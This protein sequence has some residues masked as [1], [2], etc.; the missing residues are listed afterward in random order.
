MSFRQQQV[1]VWC[2]TC[3]GSGSHEVS[4]EMASDAGEPGMEGMEIPCGD[5]GGDGWTVDVETVATH[6]TESVLPPTQGCSGKVDGWP[7][8]REPGHDAG[9]HEEKAAK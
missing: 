2:S 5:C 8:T 1:Q 7:C 6:T 4:R 9:L 3:A